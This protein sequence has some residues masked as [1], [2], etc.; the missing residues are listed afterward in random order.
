M[1]S[2]RVSQGFALDLGVA[3]GAMNGMRLSYSLAISV[4]RAQETAL[5]CNRYNCRY[6]MQCYER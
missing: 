2:S 5:V 6:Q 1:C 3:C 4:P